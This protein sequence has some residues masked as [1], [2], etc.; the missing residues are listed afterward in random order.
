MPSSFTPQAKIAA[1]ATEIIGNMGLRVPAVRSTETGISNLPIEVRDIG[2]VGPADLFISAMFFAAI[3]RY[4][5]R[6][7]ETAIRLPPVLIAYLFLVFLTGMPLPALVPI[8]I[9]FLIINWREFKLSKDEKIATW[10][11]AFIAMAM[12]G[13]GLYAKLTHKPQATPTETSHS[14][15][16]PKPPTPVNSTEPPDPTNNR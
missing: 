3:F 15:P 12:A 5:M 14:D 2:F 13:Y 9:T 1:Q 8:G 16:A 4:G 10:V 6:S 11:I 7:K